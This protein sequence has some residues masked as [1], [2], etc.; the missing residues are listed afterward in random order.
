MSTESL[1]SGRSARIVRAFVNHS[2][3]GECCSSCANRSIN[4]RRSCAVSALTSLIIL[5]SAS[6]DIA[7]STLPTF[8]TPTVNVESG[9]TS[10][11]GTWPK[12][13]RNEERPGNAAPRLTLPLH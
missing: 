13:P 10:K 5:L 4:S 9:D 8:T 7:V 1:V 11:L 3:N 12:L 6:V 2:R